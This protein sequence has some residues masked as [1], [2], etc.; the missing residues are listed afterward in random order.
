MKKQLFSIKINSFVLSASLGLLFAAGITFAWNAVWHGTDWMQPGNTINSKEMAENLEYLKR[1]VNDLN[2]RINNIEQ[3]NTSINSEN[4]PSGSVIAVCFVDNTGSE[5]RGYS[6]KCYGGATL[7][8]SRSS[9]WTANCPGDSKV[10]RIY[11]YKGDTYQTGGD[12]NPQYAQNTETV[13][14]L[15]IKQ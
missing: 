2:N 14:V 12:G 10:F 5:W 7:K 11:T 3:N 13:G 4:M 6:K 1:T 9:N 8:W 15:C